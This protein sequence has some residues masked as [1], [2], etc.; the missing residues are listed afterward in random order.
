MRAGE[1]NAS[2]RAAPGGLVPGAGS[3]YR[4]RKCRRKLLTD[5]HVVTHE[6]GDGQS[7]FRWHKRD[8]LSKEALFGGAPGAEGSGGQSGF[9]NLPTTMVGTGAAV[10]KAGAGAA[11]TCSSVFIEPMR[12]M[13]STLSDGATQGKLSCVKCN[14]RLGTFNWAGEQCSCGAWITPAFQLHR[15]NL[16]II[17]QLR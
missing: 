2:G 16:D 12:W 6:P 17:T 9:N 10:R 8:A 3:S 7:C 11:S 15:K 13:K 5:K 1:P 4:C 14:A